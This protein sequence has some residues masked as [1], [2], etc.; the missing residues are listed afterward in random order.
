MKM[1]PRP[2][3]IWSMNLWKVIYLRLKDMCRNSKRLKG[4]MTAVLGTANF[5]RGTLRYLFFK[6]RVLRTVQP[7]SW[8]E[9]LARL[10]RGYLS[11]WVARLRQR[12]S[13]HGRQLPSLLPLAVGLLDDSI[14]FLRRSPWRSIIC[15]SKDTETWM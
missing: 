11:A 1:K 7:S 14:P 5:S 3:K 8:L 9:K 6:S 13:P 4:R 15:L 2:L 12:K 10:G